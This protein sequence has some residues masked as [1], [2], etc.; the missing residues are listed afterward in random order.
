MEINLNIMAVLPVIA[1]EVTSI[2]T[3]LKRNSPGRD[4]IKAVR[5]NFIGPLTYTLDMSVTEGV[6]PTEMKLA[7]VKTLFKANDPMSFS[8]YRPVFVLPLFFWNEIGES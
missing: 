6:Y 3:D 7:K 4:S 1:T 8:N 2:I 5:P